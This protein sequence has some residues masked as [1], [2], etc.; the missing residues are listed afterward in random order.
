MDEPGF[1]L[2]RNG[3]SL[4]MMQAPLCC[5]SSTSKA[6]FI[7]CLLI[8]KLFLTLEIEPEFH[9]FCKLHETQEEG[10]PFGYFVPP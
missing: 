10:R 8:L 6:I 7:R 1:L 5:L 3:K 4:S 9:V 2:P